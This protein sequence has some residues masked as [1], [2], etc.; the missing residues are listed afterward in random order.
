MAAAVWEVASVPAGWVPV[1]L[2]LEASALAVSGSAS[3]AE[4]DL[5]PSDQ[6]SDRVWWDRVWSGR[7][8]ASVP[9]WAQD[10]AS[11]SAPVSPVWG[12]TPTM[13]KS[14]LSAPRSA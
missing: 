2:A 13:T 3:L 7:A 14:R 10:L 5:A 11:G 8:S 12:R 1:V 6:A 9:A 4:L